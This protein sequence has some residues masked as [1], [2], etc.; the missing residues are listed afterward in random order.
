MDGLVQTD[1]EYNTLTITCDS[2]TVGRV[3]AFIRSELGPCILVPK[4]AAL[5]SI[6]VRQDL[7]SPPAKQS[8][9][10]SLLLVIAGG[11]MSFII[12]IIGCVTLVGWMF[13]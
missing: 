1:Y 11:T 5:R 4:D 9:W 10:L 2:D 13:R 12:W 6:C 3:A 8:N 7:P